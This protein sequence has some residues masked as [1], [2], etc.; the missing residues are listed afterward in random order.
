MTYI[1]HKSSQ[2]VDRVQGRPSDIATSFF[3]MKSCI[4]D[5]ILDL[6]PSSD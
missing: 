2:T 6:W 4:Y 1:I 5:D 3:H